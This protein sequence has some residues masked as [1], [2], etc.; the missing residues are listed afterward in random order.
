VLVSSD[1]QQWASAALVDESG[2]DLRDPKFSVTP[3]DRLMIVAGGSVYEGTR[4]L[5]R[6]G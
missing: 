6:H 2:V 5:A 3:D 1:G 4:Y